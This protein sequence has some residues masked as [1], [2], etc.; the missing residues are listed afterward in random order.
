MKQCP[1][2]GR[3]IDDQANICQY[4]GEQQPPTYAPGGNYGFNTGYRPDYDHSNNCFDE[5]P[6]G[7][8]RGVAA[9]LAL[10]LGSFGVQ[11]FYLGK[12]AGGFICILLMIVTCGAWGIINLI[13]G[14]LMFCMDNRTFRQKY[15]LSDSTFPLF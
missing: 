10:L 3:Y 7:K 8:S 12:I 5:G 4:C 2:C 6:E 15:V 11:Y 13:Q 14:V 9:L 1:K